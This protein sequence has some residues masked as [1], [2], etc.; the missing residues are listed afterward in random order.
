MTCMILTVIGPDRPGLVRTLSQAVAAHGG[1]W[2]ESRMARLA[3]QFAGIVLVEAPES[4]LASLHALES[5][6]LR[7]VVQS[8][9]AGEMAVA[10]AA[11]TRLT[12]EVVGNDRPGIVRD[13]TRILADN[14]VNIDELT[15]NVASGS[16]SG[17][18]LFRA[19]ALLRAPNAAAAKA[20]QVGL[21]DLGNELMVDIQQ[22]PAGSSGGSDSSAAAR[23]LR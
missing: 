19:T 7:I 13:I 11:G 18:T 1:S 21:E 2:L 12:L 20:V 15:T 4:L 22:A 17:G 3:G 23:P 5:A 8:A 10:E 16:F 6:G 9:A 14:G